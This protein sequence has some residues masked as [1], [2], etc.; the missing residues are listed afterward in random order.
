MFDFEFLA[1]TSLA[2]VLDILAEHGEDASLIAG[3][4]FLTIALKLGLIASRYLVSLS[5]ISAL[6]GIE[7]IP[8][9]GLRLGALTTH[10]AIE[11]SPL[12]REKYT[13]LS[14]TY[15]QVANVRVRHQAT[16]G[17]NLAAADYASDPPAALIALGAQV[18]LLSRH[19]ERL[20]PLREF[21]VGHY[22]TTLQP[23]E[24]L[25]EVIVP[26]PPPAAR[27]IYL[28]YK[29]RSS[30]DRPCA[31]VAALLSP[32][33]EGRCETLRVVVG[34]AAEVPHLDNEA[35]VLARGE[36]L[37][38]SLIDEIACRYAETLEPVSDLRGSAWYRR[39]VSAVM[40]RRALQA[41]AHAPLE[42]RV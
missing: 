27:S 30:E 16:V 14:Q 12:C 38:P 15:T 10:R 28:K 37:T 11:T 8:G 35:L 13:L 9:R 21:I 29:S 1:P 39:E 19:G 40:V 6:Q 5:Q 18:R 22:T 34:A 17:G 2:E 7:P 4:A 36:R 20:M 41:V 33:S 25:T 42:A 23:H 26:E 31:S 32:D 24:L 3:G